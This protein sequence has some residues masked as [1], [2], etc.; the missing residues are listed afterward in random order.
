MIFL[1]TKHGHCQW[2]QITDYVNLY[3]RSL[4]SN[5]AD[6]C[7][8]SEHVPELAASLNLKRDSAR[9]AKTAVVWRFRIAKRH[10]TQTSPAAQTKPIISKPITTAAAA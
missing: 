3:T 8:E 5:A 10:A 7:G 9:P 2:I 4:T 6:S 1:A